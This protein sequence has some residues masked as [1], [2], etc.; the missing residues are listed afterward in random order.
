MEAMP[1]QIEKSTH[2]MLMLS[3]VHIRE[4]SRPIFSLTGCMLTR[5]Y[6]DNG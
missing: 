6:T 1:M 2:R 5:K 3:G 4:S